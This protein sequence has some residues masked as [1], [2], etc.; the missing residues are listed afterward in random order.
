MAIRP[1]Y[2]IGVLNLTS[3][4]ANF[5]TS[6]SALQ[7]AAVQA[8]DAI[9]APSGH[10]L[11]I[12]S[13]TGQNSG[14]LFLPCPP[15]AAG[16]GLALRIRFQPDGS[17]YQGAVRVL[18]EKL[19]SG[20]V[21]ALAGLVSAADK[22]PYFTGAGTMGVT[23]LTALARKILGRSTTADIYG[24]LGTVPDA[25]LPARLRAGSPSIG[26][27][28]NATENGFFIADGNSSNVPSSGPAVVFNHRYSST[29][30]YQRWVSLTGSAVYERRQ[31]GGTWS[32]WERSNVEKP[33]LAA[34][35]GSDVAGLSQIV[36]DI[37]NEYVGAEV[38][39]RGLRTQSG[40][41]VYGFRCGPSGGTLTTSYRIRLWNQ[42]GNEAFQATMQENV[43]NGQIASFTN[44]PAPLCKA[45]IHFGSGVNGWVCLASAMGWTNGGGFAKTERSIWSNTLGLMRRLA[46]V[47]TVPF[48]NAS[49]TSV[50]IYGVR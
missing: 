47:S 36:L 42:Y 39:I 31:A 6:G 34:Y 13:I 3:S 32:A 1:D 41:G 15:A 9:I 28:N 5:T 20:N 14:T 26:N 11:I 21:E 19:A 38:E 43:D 35:G 12:A 22:L 48:G 50:R 16:T 40:D 49:E 7:T 33:L 46:I 24:D 10:V 4:S 8:G 37:P 2:D 29:G 25:Q 23:G 45:S 30:G 27:A 18:I 17:R 44:V